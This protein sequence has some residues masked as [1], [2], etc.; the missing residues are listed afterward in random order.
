MKSIGYG[1]TS[2]AG[3]L[4]G[5]GR[6]AARAGGRRP[7]LRRGRGC[8]PTSAS[9]LTGGGGDLP[10]RAVGLRQVDAAPHRRRR[11]AAGPRAPC[12]IGGRV[13]VGRGRATSRPRAAAIGLMFQDYALFPHL[14]VLDNVTF[15]QRLAAVRPAA[16]ARGR[17]LLD[18][19][20][21]PGFAAR[22]VRRRALGR[23]AAAGG[24]GA[25]AGARSRSCLMLDEPFSGLDNRLRDGIRDETLDIL[26]EEGTAVLLVTHE[27]EEAMRMADRIALMRAGRIVQEGAPF[28]HLQRAGRQAGGDVLLRRQRRARRWSRAA[29][30]RRRSAAFPTPGP[31]GAAP[32]SRSSSGRST[33][34]VDFDRNGSRARCR[35]PQDGVPARGRVLRARFVGDQCARRGRRWSTTARC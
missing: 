32:R 24:A 4:S 10:A 25:G 34:S 35:P 20:G 23:G 8:S 11:R 16:K 18:L 33:C 7:R 21:L 5:P 17:E 12:A 30:P 22:D 6:G 9:T 13:R 14:S 27:P 31:R 29:R 3:R 26:K 2:G 19:V 15:G 1:A 28:A